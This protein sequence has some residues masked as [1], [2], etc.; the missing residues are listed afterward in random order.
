MKPAPPVISTCLPALAC[1]ICPRIPRVPGF[2]RRVDEE[3]I[4]ALVRRGIRRPCCENA[5]VASDEMQIARGAVPLDLVDDALRL[6]HVDLLE[7]GAG[8]AELGQWLW[9]AHWF[10]HLIW[11]EEITRLAEALPAEWRTGTMCDPQILL[12]F[13]HVGPVP[14]V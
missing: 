4:A 14:Q 1:D 5:G 7:R 11:R 9:G 6:L 12:Q 2:I 3:V 13:P 8:P 10:P